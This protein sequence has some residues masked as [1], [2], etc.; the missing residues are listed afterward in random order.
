MTHEDAFLLE[1]LE[2]PQDDLPRRIYADWLMDRPDHVSN[3]RGEFI[4]IQLDLARVPPGEPRPQNLTQRER[5]LVSAHGR[6]WGTQ[7]HRLG[8]KCWEYRRGF[9]EGVG[10]PAWALL[11]HAG[12]LFRVAPIDELKLYESAGTLSEVGV[13]PQLGRVRVLDLEKNNL[14]DGDIDALSRSQHLGGLRGLML[15]SNRVGDA[16]LRSLLGGLPVLERLD[17]SANII[18]DAGA[19]SLSYSPALGRFRIVDL[20]ANQI[21][22]T[23]ALALAASE[24]SATLGWIDLAKNPIGTAGQAALRVKLGGKVHVTG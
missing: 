7:F 9:V 2:A 10:L 12:A 6:E 18:G 16:G 8:C 4:H 17:L 14:G 11:S 15:W 22:D 13:C 1:I 5:E 24:Y 23:G 21:G 20:S 19:E 3:A